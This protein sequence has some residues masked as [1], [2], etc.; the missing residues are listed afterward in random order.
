MSSK[1]IMVIDAKDKEVSDFLEKLRAAGHLR[2]MLGN[3][4]FS[5]KISPESVSQKG[6][7]FL[8]KGGRV[9]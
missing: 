7:N 1:E 9:D 4:V 2:V 8:T 3:E 5:V 6:R